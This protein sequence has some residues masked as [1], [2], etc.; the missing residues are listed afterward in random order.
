MK[1]Y[2]YICGVAS[3]EDAFIFYIED[4]VLLSALINLVNFCTCG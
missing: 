2:T 3:K 4:G 1:K